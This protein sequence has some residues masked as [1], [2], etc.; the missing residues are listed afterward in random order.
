VVSYNC[1][2]LEE[3]YMPDEGSPSHNIKG[4]ASFQDVGVQETHGAGGPDDMGAKKA[5][6]SPFRSNEVEIDRPLTTTGNGKENCIDL[7]FLLR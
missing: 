3:K 1:V 2:E 5:P 7:V 4:D 6:E